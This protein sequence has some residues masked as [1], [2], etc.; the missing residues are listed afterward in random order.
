MTLYFQEFHKNYV[1]RENLISL[2]ERIV[3]DRTEEG[4][5]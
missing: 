3:S 5:L 4:H 2:L 1:I